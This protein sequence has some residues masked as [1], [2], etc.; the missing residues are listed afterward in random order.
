MSPR[1]GPHVCGDDGGV[2]TKSLSVLDIY[3]PLGNPLEGKLPCREAKTSLN[4]A[5][6]FSLNR[7]PPKLNPPTRFLH[8]CAIYFILKW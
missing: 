7:L 5:I 2:D 6:V 8:D 3:L 1:Q 4:S